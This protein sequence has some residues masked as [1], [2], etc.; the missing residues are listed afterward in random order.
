MFGLCDLWGGVRKNRSLYVEEKHKV[1]GA[2]E[3]MCT[4]AQELSGCW[5]ND[6]RMIKGYPWQE[7]TRREKCSKKFLVYFFSAHLKASQNI[8]KR[9]YSENVNTQY[10]AIRWFL[11][12][13]K[14][15]LIHHTIH[16]S[17]I[18]FIIREIFCEHHFP[19]LIHLVL[20][21]RSNWCLWASDMKG[22]T[23]S[24]SSISN[25]S[26]EKEI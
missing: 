6:K 7:R 20:I 8:K 12:W 18:H 21:V 10:F 24:K 11:L 3:Q 13:I 14:L 16:N 9:I 23:Y 15:S 25:A 1:S 22:Q 4:A 5:W 26:Y 19:S 2:M 17:S